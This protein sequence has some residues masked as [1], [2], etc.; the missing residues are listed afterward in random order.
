MRANNWRIE[1]GR[2]L[3]FEPEFMQKQAVDVQL[4]R[5]DILFRQ[6]KVLEE[7]LPKSIKHVLDDRRIIDLFEQST[8]VFRQNRKALESSAERMT[9]I[10]KINVLLHDHKHKKKLLAYKKYLLSKKNSSKKD[11]KKNTS[12]TQKKRK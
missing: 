11:S 12:S 1:M 5:E 6:K 10:V 8:S 4:D 9:R 7:S 3:E 2:L